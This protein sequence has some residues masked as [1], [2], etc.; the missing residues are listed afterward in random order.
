MVAEAA[1][2][3]TRQARSW[4]ERLNRESAWS[5]AAGGGKKVKEFEQQGWG[6]CGAGLEK[7]SQEAKATGL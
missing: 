7:R 3:G 4:P 6:G 1:A 2:G 5:P